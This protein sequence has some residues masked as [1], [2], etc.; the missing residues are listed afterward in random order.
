MTDHPGWIGLAEHLRQYLADVGADRAPDGR[1]LVSPDGIA[2]GL[3]GQEVVIDHR[4]IY[5]RQGRPR[6][7]AADLR[8]TAYGL[9]V[10]VL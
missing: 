9:A 6:P 7:L 8:A 10:E 5:W 4:A 3:G 2:V 1:Y